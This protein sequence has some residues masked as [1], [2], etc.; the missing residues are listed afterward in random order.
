MK[1]E[2]EIRRK[3]MPRVFQSRVSA[4]CA[5]N[6]LP[7]L[8][9]F[10]FL[11]A[12]F[13]LPTSSFAQGRHRIQGSVTA[14]G[15]Y[16]D[17]MD[18]GRVRLGE[19][20]D[21]FFVVENKGTL[22]DTLFNLDYQTAIAD[23]AFTADSV[24]SP[25]GSTYPLPPPSGLAR[26]TVH[27]HPTTLGLHTSSIPIHS[28]PGI[29][30]TPTF[31]LRGTGVQ[32]NVV[33]SGHTFP[34]VPVDSSSPP[35]IVSILNL[36]SDTTAIDNVTV[37]NPAELADSDF[38]VTLDSLPPN[39]PHLSPLRIGY[40]G[41]DNALSF[42]VQFQPRT[43]GRD[44]LIVRIHTIDGDALFDT[45]TGRGVEPLVLLS[46]PVID[47]G[48]ITLQKSLIAPAPLDTFFVISNTLGTYR[49]ELDTLVHTDTNGNFTVPFNQPAFSHEMLAAGG[50]ILDSVRFNI[51]QEGDFTDTIYI[52]NS[53]RYGLYKNS[54]SV[55]R[56]MVILKAKVRTGSIGA[57][58]VS[59]DTITTCDTVKRT[60]SITNPYPVEIYIDT[61]SFA[62]DT[63]GFSYDH[64]FGQFGFPIS[65][66]P[67]GSYPL[68]LDYSFP[69]DSLNG[70]QAFKM[71]LFQR[72]R[73]NDPPVIDTV[74][75]SL[76]R[77]QQTMILQA[78]APLPGATGTSADDIS[79]LRLPITLVGPRAGVTELNS[80]T[81]SFQFSNDLFVPTGIDV[82]G[83][84][85]V[86]GDPSYSLTPYW[87]QSTRTYTIIATGTAVSDPAK[88]ANK[89]LLTILMQAYVTTDTVVTVTPTF[90][91]AKR[92]CAYN[93][94]SFTLSI[95][96]ANDCGDQTI[97]EV[98]EHETP[99][100]ILTGA[101]PNPV[102]S[103]G[104]AFI[105]Y[106]ADEASEVT[107]TVFSAS[108]DP[109][110]HIVTTVAAGAGTIALPEQLIP[111]SGPAFVRMQ[112]V[113]LNGNISAIQTCKIAVM[114]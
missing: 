43:I 46:N 5:A 53:T 12:Y 71:A 89:L 57:F 35:Q 42:T 24:R 15:I 113:G 107:T 54:D 87:D 65:I 106:R 23:P 59:F 45:I 52:P 40:E 49:A 93:L 3:K 18:F 92:P 47:F 97:R 79:E 25:F 103:G 6:F 102:T 76:V 13:L 81:L 88:I 100:F 108:G 38:I 34:D 111:A 67:N 85:S 98:L 50:T 63:G 68:Y 41:G 96:Y 55:Y 36:G 9:C 4:F 48:T 16:P 37:L 112:A 73:D 27:F 14:L 94:Q 109:L 60:V 17:T 21:S 22:P 104:G 83:S 99:S 61:I 26:D 39:G 72:R 28:S 51:T 74:T 32:P 75:A 101:W 105:G 29:S 30:P 10:L 66:P 80:W 78:I 31:Y 8:S 56:P 82:A 77:K 19:L 90:T 7:L 11:T 95:P 33:S 44:T 84:L 69:Y 62:S 91:W 86:A 114:R 58:A 1:D 64:Q 20:R 70:L 110:G 2:V